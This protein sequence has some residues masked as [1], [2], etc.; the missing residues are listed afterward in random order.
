[1]WIVKCDLCGGTVYSGDAWKQI[2]ATLKSLEG[3]KG[4]EIIYDLCKECGNKFED[5]MANRFIQSIKEKG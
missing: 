5:F 1:M 2:V 3:I 4:P